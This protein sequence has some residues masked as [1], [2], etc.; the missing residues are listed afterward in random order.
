[1]FPNILVYSS[2]FLPVPGLGSLPSFICLSLE[3]AAALLLARAST[4]PSPIPCPP[5]RN[6]LQQTAFSVFLLVGVPVASL[7]VPSLPCRWAWASKCYFPMTFQC[8]PMQH[9]T[10]RPAP[11][12]SLIIAGDGFGLLPLPKKTLQLCN[13]SSV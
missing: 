5:R 6:P 2:H 4:S 10:E 12:V 1:M 7:L 11:N 13:I 9:Y 3:R 8:K